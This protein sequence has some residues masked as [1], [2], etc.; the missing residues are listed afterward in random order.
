[1][2]ADNVALHAFAHTC[3]NQ[4]LLSARPTAANLQEWVYCCGPML[5]QT[6][7]W[8]P[9]HFRDHA[10]HAGSANSS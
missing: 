2:Y 3:S 6:G 9:Y 8:M 5:G 1:M 7:G 4:Y 10:L